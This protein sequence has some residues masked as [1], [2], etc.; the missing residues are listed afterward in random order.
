MD[1]EVTSVRLVINP[2][3]MVI[4]EA[5]RA[6]TYLNLFG[7]NTDAIMVNRVLPLE[8]GTGYWSTWREIHEKY[9][10]EIRTCFS[11]LPIFRIPMMEVEVHGLPML[12]RIDE[13]AFAECDSSADPLQGTNSGDS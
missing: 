7:F 11:P 3:K 2:E 5:R 13:A 9:E 8:A 12:E 10:E 4:A 1:E 6:F